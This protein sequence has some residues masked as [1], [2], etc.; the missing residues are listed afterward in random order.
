M[1]CLEGMR[2]LLEDEIVDVVVTSPPYNFGVRYGRCDDSRPKG[3]YLNWMG[4]VGKEIRR[5]LKRDGSFF[6]NLGPRPTDPWAPWEVAFR[7]RPHFVL[8]N[9]IIWVTAIVVK[10][11]AHGHY[12]PIGGKRFLSDY[13]EYIFHFTK[14]GDVELDR[15]AIGVPYKD[16]RNLRRWKGASQGLRCRGNV[17]FIP[18]ETVRGKKPHPASFPP[19]LPEMCIKLHGLGRTKLVLDPFMGIGSTALAC[20]KLGV[21]FIGFEIEEDYV[22]EARRRLAMRPP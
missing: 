9:V 4:E 11:E 19:E 1:D 21:G 5:V 7:L 8:Q 15:L 13:F 12:R 6:L 16:E 10:G 17:W 18:Y 22:E 3:E 14:F 20:A 2:T